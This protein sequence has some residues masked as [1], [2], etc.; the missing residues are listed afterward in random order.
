MDHCELDRRVVRLRAGTR[1]RSISLWGYPPRGASALLSETKVGCRAHRDGLN[2][3]LPIGTGF[4]V[5]AGV[6]PPRR[7]H[8]AEPKQFVRARAASVALRPRLVPEAPVLEKVPR[9][10]RHLRGPQQRDV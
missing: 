5:V 10:R 9:L 8:R 1:E 4:G 6:F 3:A 2:V 7:R